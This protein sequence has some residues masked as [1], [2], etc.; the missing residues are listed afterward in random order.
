M[1]GYNEVTDHK[2]IQYFKLLGKKG[3]VPKGLYYTKKVGDKKEK[4]FCQFIEGEIID[5]KK[6]LNTPKAGHSWQ[7]HYT[8]EI[9]FENMDNE[10]E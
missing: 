5:I 3:N 7:A 2:K 9:T 4:V 8:Y 10:A 1:A 6:V